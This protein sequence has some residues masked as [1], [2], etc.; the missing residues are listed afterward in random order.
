M[1]KD[2]FEVSAPDLPEA[3]GPSAPLSLRIVLS[4]VPGIAL[5]WGQLWASVAMLDW[6]VGSLIFPGLPGI[7]IVGVL[8]LG[9]ALWAS[10]RV[11][12]TAIESERLIAAN[13]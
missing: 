2:A 11:M 10:W 8:T 6:S 7:A 9:P 1:F 13:G 5:L 3:A 12:W 4:A